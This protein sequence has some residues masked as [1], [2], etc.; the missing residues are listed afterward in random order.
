MAEVP[1]PDHLVAFARARGEAGERW[2]ERLPGL[3]ATLSE[4]WAVELEPPF[5]DPPGAAGWLAPGR[6]ADGTPVVL[7]LA[8]PHAEARTEAAGLRCFDG[9]GAVRLLDADEAEFALLLERVEPGHD[10]WSVDVDTGAEVTAALL[11][12]LWRPPPAGTA[13]GTL[14]A[15]VDTWIDRLRD[16]HP[17]YPAAAVRAAID[18]GRS[19]ADTQPDPVVLHGDLHPFNILRSSDRGWLAIDPKP[20]IGDPA[21]D[22]AQYLGN[23]VEGAL[24]AHDPQREL[25]RQIDRF[26]DLLGLDRRRVAGWAAVKA[27]AWNFGVADV[28]LFGAIDTALA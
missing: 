12:R 21:Y 20:L 13:I 1:I 3:V 22:L 26:A 17:R 24:P 14:A 15:E 8:W 5:G 25:L 18:R 19:L 2:L 28:A 7:K 23:R 11:R 16:G 27:V 6:L 4:R 9:D 10:L